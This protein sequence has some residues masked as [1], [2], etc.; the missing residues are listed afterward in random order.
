QG[1]AVVAGSLSKYFPANQIYSQ[2]MKFKDMA[3]VDYVRRHMDEF[4]LKG[5]DNAG[6][7]TFGI[8]GGG[9]AYIMSK[10]PIE[11]VSD[12][13]NRKVWIPD[14]DKLSREAVDTFGISPITLPL[15][16]VR[17]GLSS[18]LIDTVATSPV[19]AIVLQWH[20]Q[21]R[22]VTN[23]PLLY[24]HA[25]LAIDKKRFN[26]ISKADRAVVSQIM[27]RIFSEIDHQNR[28]DD[29]KAV[30]ALKKRGIQF[31]DPQGMTRDEWISTA[32]RASEKMVTTGVLPRDVVEKM[33]QLLD[34]FHA[35]ESQ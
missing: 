21:V 22:Y 28:E 1:G 3:E 29:S 31:I 14:N 4:I 11:T 32:A 27:T 2:P 13:K 17:T 8:S 30:E 6:F 5:L 18:G 20:T 23:I 19:G 25:V 26:R 9:F 10:E 7:V 24:L 33:D 16:D 35:K 12:L 34:E 15:A